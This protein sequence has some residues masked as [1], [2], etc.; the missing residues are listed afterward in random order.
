MKII[1]NGNVFLYVEYA[2]IISKLFKAVSTGSVKFAV[3]FNKSLFSFMFNDLTDL[4][5]LVKTGYNFS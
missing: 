3:G 5:K 4:L 1:L 2:R